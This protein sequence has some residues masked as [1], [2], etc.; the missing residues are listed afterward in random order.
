VQQGKYKGGRNLPQLKLLLVFGEDSRLPF[1]YRKL[2]GNTPDS[3]T[4]KNYLAEL[5]VLGLNKTKVVMDRG[6]F[7][8]PN[9]NGLYKEHIKFLIGAK[10]SLKLV[11]QALDG[12]YDEI[13]SFENYSQKHDVYGYTVPS[14]WDY[15]QER[16]YKGDVLTEK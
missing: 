7:S 6:F 16:P 2:A 3:K 13:R 11:R 1:Y 15:E 4:V 12:V 10:I 14:E 8:E 5:D 9:I